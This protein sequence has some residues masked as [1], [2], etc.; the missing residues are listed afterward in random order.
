M[1][2]GYKRHTMFSGYKRHTMFSGYKQINVSKSIT[3]LE[4]FESYCIET[5]TVELLLTTVNLQQRHY[6]WKTTVKPT[7]DSC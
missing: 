3:Y 2:S 7:L 6:E 5:N 1:F 4:Y